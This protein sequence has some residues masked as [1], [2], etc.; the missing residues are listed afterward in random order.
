MPNRKVVMEDD[1]R[2][3]LQ[4]HMEKQDKVDDLFSKS[5]DKVTDLS[6]SQTKVILNNSDRIKDLN[7]SIKFILGIQLATLIVISLVH[8][9]HSGWFDNIGWLQ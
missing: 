6:K 2:L 8:A 4:K 1:V 7:T 9:Q 3:V 5:L